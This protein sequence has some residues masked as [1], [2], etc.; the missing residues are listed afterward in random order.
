MSVYNVFVAGLSGAGLVL[1]GFV[2]TQG[3]SDYHLNAAQLEGKLQQAAEA[4][5]QAQNLM[6]SFAEAMFAGADY[7]AA[8]A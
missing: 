6:S 1:L 3:Q 5:L 2:T 8:M 4:A 7:V